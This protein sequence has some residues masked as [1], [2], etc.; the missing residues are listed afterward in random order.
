M[1]LRACAHVCVRVCVCVCVCVCGCVCVCV[2]AKE[3]VRLYESVSE[4]QKGR[5]IDIVSVS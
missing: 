4:I 2:C 1:K 5:E 3:G